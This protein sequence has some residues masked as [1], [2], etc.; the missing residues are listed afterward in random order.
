MF[1]KSDVFN[2][3]VKIAL[4]MLFASVWD[5][6][7]SLVLHHF[8]ATVWVLHRCCSSRSYLSSCQM[9]LFTYV[10]VSAEIKGSVS[11][12]LSLGLGIVTGLCHVFSSF[13]L[14]IRDLYGIGVVDCVLVWNQ[15]CRSYLVM[16]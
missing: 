8:C 10:D 5:A 1:L 14:G 12:S 7:V 15:H 4:K 16:K 2:I 3:S 13:P 9:T 6:L 11:T